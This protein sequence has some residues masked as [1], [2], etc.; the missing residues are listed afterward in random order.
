MAIDL[1]LRAPAANPLTFAQ[2][3]SNFNQLKA[4]IEKC[5]LNTHNHNDLYFLKNEIEYIL[6]GI[7][8][9]TNYTYVPG[10]G[11]MWDHNHLG[12]YGFG[13]GTLLA[14]QTETTVN[15]PRGYNSVGPVVLITTMDNPSNATLFPH[16]V[17]LGSFKV[18]NR[19][20]P[21]SHNVDFRWLALGGG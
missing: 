1:N 13:W 10:A 3:D 4:A 17:G 21:L 8:K 18:G 20:F 14:G 12:R 11:A 15:F 5:S 19:F 6:Y 9:M 7:T 16:P 2:V